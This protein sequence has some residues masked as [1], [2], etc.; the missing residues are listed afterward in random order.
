MRFASKVVYALFLLLAVMMIVPAAAQ[1][2]VK[3]RDIQFVHPDSLK[4]PGNNRDRSPMTGDTVSVVGVVVTGPRSL[5]TGQRWSF[6]LA[7]TA[8]GEWNFIQVVQHDTTN[9]GA[10]NTN[11][12]ALQVGDVIRITGLIAEAFSDGLIHTHTQLEPFTAPP[13]PVEFLDIYNY[14]LPKPILV[15]I[16]DLASLDRGEKYESAYVRIEN[17]TM[18]N[19]NSG[20]TN[21]QA[22]IQDATGQLVLDDWFNPVHR[23]ID[24]AAGG[25]A[26]NIPL[27]YPSNGAR[28]NLVGWIRDFSNTQ[29]FALGVE[30][31][32]AFELLTNPPAMTSITRNV[33]V[34]TSLQGVIVRAK[35]VDNGTVASAKVFYSIDN[36]TTWQGLA[37][38]ADTANFYQA[39]IPPQPDG[40]FVRY[41]LWSQDNDGHISTEPIDILTRTFFYTVRDNGPTIYDIQYTPFASGISGYLGSTVTVTG[42]VTADSTDFSNQF[43]IQDGTIPWNGLWVRDA[44]NKPKRGDN[45]TVTGTI[46]EIFDQ[47]QLNVTTL[48]AVKI[49]SHGNAIPNPVVIKTG[50]IRTGAATAESY[51]GMLVQI[52]NIIVTDPFPNVPGGLGEFAVNDGSGAVLVD[53][54]SNEFNGNRDSTFAAGDSIRVLT[55]VLVYDFNNFRIA[56]RNNADIVRIKTSVKDQSPLSFVYRLEQNYPNPFNPETSIRYQLAK[57][58]QVNLVIYNMLGQKVRTLVN[59]AKTLG[60]QAQVWDGKNDRGLI[61]PTGIYFYRLQSGA[62][63]EVKKMLVVR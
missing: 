1:Q 59:G 17:A 32:A 58:G 63:T 30:G 3:I 57:A 44:L 12:S 37:M 26:Q 49:N 8:Y 60:N 41:Y 6:I 34:P 62:F 50:N 14:P 28:F 7:D 31:K 16:A 19:N 51:E 18:L 38:T 9:A 61:V 52:R 40:K 2:N 39:V 56:P 27:V 10:V 15:T 5:W 13:V 48:N 35:I 47:T 21:G 22:L 43:F 24:R 53:D 33:G 46:E 36:G 20:N 23:L 29:R 54:R 45:V 4:L 11:V 42:T 55:G 25:N